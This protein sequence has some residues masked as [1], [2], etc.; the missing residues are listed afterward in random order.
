MERKPGSMEWKGSGFGFFTLSNRDRSLP[1]KLRAFCTG[2]STGG[3]WSQWES[4]FH[5]NCLE[6][7]AGAFAVKTFVK[8][9]FQVREIHSMLLRVALQG[10]VFDIYK[11]KI[12][13]SVEAVNSDEGLFLK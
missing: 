10:N 2:V 1:T 4:L 12:F 9:K 8:G 5:I 13:Y 11:S 3:P 7:L 6:L